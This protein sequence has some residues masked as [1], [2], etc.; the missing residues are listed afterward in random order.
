[1]ELNSKGKL[2]FIVSNREERVF[3]F[4]LWQTQ[5]QSK[6]AK[7][8][9]KQTDSRVQRGPGG[10]WWVWVSGKRQAGG[11][12]APL[13]RESP[14]GR[15]AYRASRALPSPLSTFMTKETR[16]IGKCSDTD[17]HT[18]TRSQ[19]FSWCS[20]PALPPAA[21]GL[22]GSLIRQTMFCWSLRRHPHLDLNSVNPNEPFPPKLL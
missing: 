19:W 6:Q 15:R 12:S 2:F 16:W 10:C 14:D 8:T 11:S 21:E 9:V 22:V 4:F 5:K 13:W 20:R 1:M 7:N 3:L 18:H 17:T